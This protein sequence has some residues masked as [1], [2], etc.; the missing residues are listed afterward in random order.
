MKH[1]CAICEGTEK[2]LTVFYGLTLTV[3]GIDP[4]KG[5]HAHPRCVS[6]LKSNVA[7]KTPKHRGRG[8]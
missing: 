1:T 2:G 5:Y 8:R 3:L 6:L 7:G 4:S